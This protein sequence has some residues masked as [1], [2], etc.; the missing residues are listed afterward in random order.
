[1]FQVKDERTRTETVGKWLKSNETLLQPA[2]IIL[3]PILKAIY[4]YSTNKGSF[5]SHKYVLD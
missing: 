5:N 1:M 4:P 3:I 2:T